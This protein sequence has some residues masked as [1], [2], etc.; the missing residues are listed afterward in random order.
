MSAAPR[1]RSRARPRGE[2]PA[3]L[4]IAFH[5][6]QLAELL[7]RRPELH[8]IGIAAAVASARWEA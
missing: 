1:F 4:R 2:V 6:T 3:A 7:A 8:G 5:S